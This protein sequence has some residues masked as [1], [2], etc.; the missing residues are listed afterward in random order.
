MNA[1]LPIRWLAAGADTSGFTKHLADCVVLT[2]DRKILMQQR[3]EGWGK[4]GGY[5]NIFGGHVEP[6]ETPM[7]GMIRELNE[8]LGAIVQEK[9]VIVVGGITEDWT[10]HQEL[11]YIHFWHD[12][13]GTIT[14]CY[15]CEAR[16]YDTLDAA[17][18]HPKLM[19][20][21]RAA[22]LRCREMGLL[23]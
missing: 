4:H 22:L 5:L 8:E 1:D 16:T 3:P 14:G 13:D 20:Y 17:L 7:Q 9:D 6:G 10:D 15:E 21:A 23:P 19:D 11:V 2:K 18:A 12:R